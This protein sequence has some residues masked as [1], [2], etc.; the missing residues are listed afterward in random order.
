LEEPLRP[1]VL[2]FSGK[3]LVDQDVSLLDLELIPSVT[4]HFNWDQPC[5]E[6]ETS[7]LKETIL[8]LLEN[9]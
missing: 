8:A 7:F 2:L 6:S 3:K 9:V 4:L 5:A 1:F